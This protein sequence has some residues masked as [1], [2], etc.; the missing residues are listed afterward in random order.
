MKLN[1]VTIVYNDINGIDLTLNSIISNRQ[2]IDKYIVIDGASKDGTLDVLKNNEAESKP[3]RR[4]GKVKTVASLKSFVANLRRKDSYRFGRTVLSCERCKMMESRISL[5]T[6]CAKN[7][8]P[9]A[10]SRCSDSM[11]LRV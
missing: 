11:K 10:V 8:L 7:Y 4:R 3:S 9:A 6:V 1:V 5:D 2:Y